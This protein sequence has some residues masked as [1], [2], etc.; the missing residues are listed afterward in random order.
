MINVYLV[1][2]WFTRKR[3][4]VIGLVLAGTSLGNAA[5]PKLN[6]W[7]LQATD[8]QQVFKWIAWVPVLIDSLVVYLFERLAVD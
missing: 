5:F 1:S 6:G 4:L 8:W 2:N 7:L 3:G